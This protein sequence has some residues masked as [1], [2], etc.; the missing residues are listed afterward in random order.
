MTA[1]LVGEKIEHF[2]LNFLKLK[3]ELSI[4]QS[5]QFISVDHEN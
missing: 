3:C 5:T 4:F 2:E 1:K